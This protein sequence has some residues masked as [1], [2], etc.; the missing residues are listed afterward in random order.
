M[1][2]DVFHEILIMEIS[3]KEQLMDNIIQQSEL[4][5]T[6]T[7]M[8]DNLKAFGASTSEIQEMQP[9]IHKYAIAEPVPENSS[10]KE[11]VLGILVSASFIIRAIYS[12]SNG[13]STWGVIM[14]IV[15]LVGIISIALSSYWNKL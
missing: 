3:R 7:E 15:G 1:I 9:L 5:F 4:G 10:T 14:F 13:N 6:K 12:L 8:K 11:K 2:F